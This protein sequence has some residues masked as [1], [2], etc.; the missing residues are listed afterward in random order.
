MHTLCNQLLLE[1]SLDLFNTL[2]ICYTLTHILQ[3][4]IKKLDVEKVFFDKLTG[5]L[6]FRM[7]ASRNNG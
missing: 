3:M 4:F 2:H 5:F 1:L 6:T 7:T